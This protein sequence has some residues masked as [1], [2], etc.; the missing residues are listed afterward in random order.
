MEK[1][2]F[3]ALHRRSLALRRRFCGGLSRARHARLHVTMS[4]SSTS[5]GRTAFPRASCPTSSGLY[6]HRQV[7]RGYWRVAQPFDLSRACRT[8]LAP[9]HAWPL[10]RTRPGHLLLGEGPIAWRVPAMLSFV[11][12]SIAV[13]LIGRR[14]YGRLSGAVAALLFTFSPQAHPRQRLEA[15]SKATS[16][17]L[18]FL[19]QRG[20]AYTRRAAH[21]QYI[22]L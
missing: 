16:G 4:S 15:I 22:S 8:Q 11:L 14:F 18:H 5:P 3:R 20:R 12:S 6:H 13:F 19:R 10:L 9:L 17:K 1:V 2:A 21:P 7:A